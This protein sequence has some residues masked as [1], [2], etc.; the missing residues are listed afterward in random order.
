[1]SEKYENFREAQGLKLL[2]SCDTEVVEEQSGRIQQVHDVLLLESKK[3]NLE[4]Q[5]ENQEKIKIDAFRL[6]G[7]LFQRYIMHPRSKE[8]PGLDFEVPGPQNLV[9]KLTLKILL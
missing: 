1:M 8:S 2:S 9:K 7:H 3:N 6:S 5:S 4:M